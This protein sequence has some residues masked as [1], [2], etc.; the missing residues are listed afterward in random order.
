MRVPELGHL[1]AH[2]PT[3][4]LQLYHSTLLPL[5]RAPAHLRA[6]RLRSPRSP[7][8]WLPQS[9]RTMA[10]PQLLLRVVMLMAP[11]LPTLLRVFQVT[12]LT[13]SGITSQQVRGGKSGGMRSPQFTPRSY[14]A[15]H[16]VPNGTTSWMSSTYKISPPSR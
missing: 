7:T 4:S 1:W 15:S 16:S 13:V 10:S 14:M 2:S 3:T 6:C 5:P 11:P 9:P 12:Q 8:P